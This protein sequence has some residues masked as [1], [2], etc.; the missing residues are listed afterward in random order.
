M[1]LLLGYADVRKLATM[2]RQD[3]VALLECRQGEDR[4]LQ[5]DVRAD[6]AKFIPAIAKVTKSAPL[7]AHVWLSFAVDAPDTVVVKLDGLDLDKGELPFLMRTFVRISTVRNQ[8]FSGLPK[9]EWLTADRESE[10]IRIDVS[11]LLEEREAKVSASLRECTVTE[12]GLKVVGD[13]ISPA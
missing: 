2:F 7:T 5:I 1:E 3:G 6:L 13:L 10:T 12:S 8:L 4:N 9:K 11:A